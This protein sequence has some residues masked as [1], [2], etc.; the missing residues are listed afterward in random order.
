MVPQYYPLQT[1][2]SLY[3]P[4]GQYLI[5][6]NVQSGPQ[7]FA[8]LFGY[9]EQPLVPQPLPFPLPFIAPAVPPPRSPQAGGASRKKGAARRVEPY[10]R[11]D[12]E[13]HPDIQ[14]MWLGCSDVLLADGKTWRQH[15]KQH[16]DND[17]TGQKRIPC[18]W[19]GCGKDVDRSGMFRHAMGTHTS[20][21]HESCPYCDYTGRGDMLRRHIQKRH[22]APAGL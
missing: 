19:F 12:L 5:P 15:M 13:G 18:L 3:H 4:N 14:C 10:A 8:H 17:A 1:T 21:L 16:V 2:G 20:L 7:F 11:K 9:P 6:M 22:A